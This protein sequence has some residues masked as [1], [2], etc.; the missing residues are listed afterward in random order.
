MPLKVCLPVPCA[1]IWIADCW[2]S[3]SLDALIKPEVLVLKIGVPVGEGSSVSAWRSC[4]PRAAWALAVIP[5]RVL[6]GRAA[7]IP[8][9]KTNPIS[10][11]ARSRS[12]RGGDECA[13]GE[14][15][16]AGVPLWRVIYWVLLA[17]DCGSFKGDAL[18]IRRI[19]KFYGAVAEGECRNSRD[20]PTHVKTSL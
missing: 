3:C 2:C 11:A 14:D 20:F 1:S 12:Q 10:V 19:G 7:Q 9:K 13:R 16:G 8:N 6:G 4:C 17:V 5:I 15:R 18:G